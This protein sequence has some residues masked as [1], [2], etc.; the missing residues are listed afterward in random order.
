[1]TNST[2][3]STDD[4]IDHLKRIRCRGQLASVLL[5]PDY[6]TLAS[7][8]SGQAFIR[9]EGLGDA[10][11]DEPVGFPDLSRLIQAIEWV[12]VEGGELPIQLDD[13][14]ARVTSGTSEVRFQ[15]HGPDFITSHPDDE[16]GTVP[17]EC[18]EAMEDVPNEGQEWKPDL[19]EQVAEAI[20][21]VSAEEVDL[22]LQTDET[23]LS[24]GSGLTKAKIR[25]PFLTGPKDRKPELDASVLEDVLEVCNRPTVS[26]QTDPLNRPWVTVHENGYT[27]GIRVTEGD[28]E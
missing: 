22:L 15:L 1:M 12:N 3:V 26:W 23:W 16:D 17:S 25:V 4:L 7:V 11:W 24:I 28:D 27:Y 20:P 18:Y 19:V 10:P 21:L 14:T 5:Q 13:R 6:R 9:A 8:R 2:N